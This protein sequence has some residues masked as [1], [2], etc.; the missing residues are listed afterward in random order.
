M[1]TTTTLIIVAVFVMAGIV[2][3]V[4]GLGLQVL[5]MVLLVII[6]PPIEAAALLVVPGL[7][8]NIWQIATGPPPWPMVKR[9]WPLMAGIVVGTW[10]GDRLDIG[11]M[12]PQAGTARIMLAVTIIVYAALGLAKWR[13]HIPRSQQTWAAPV[14]GMANGLLTAATGV[15][16][17]PAV[18]YLAALGLDKDELVQALGLVFLTA[19]LSL[20]VNLGMA[21]ALNA[22][23]GWLSLLAL[24]AS[25]TGMAL[26]QAVRDRLNAETFRTCFYAGLLGLGVFVLSRAV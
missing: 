13:F 2:K 23:I 25:L 7:V 17:V 8:S 20:A 18:P 19:T 5:P 22:G 12:G 16:V 3:G 11:M 4:I 9:L 14:V 24:A 26:G 1:V 6:M 21:G 10:L 15:F